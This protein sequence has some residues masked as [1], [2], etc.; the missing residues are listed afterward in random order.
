MS[1]PYS[2]STNCK[3]NDLIN[4]E[5]DHDNKSDDKYSIMCRVILKRNSSN[6]LYFLTVNVL[7]ENLVNSS[8]QIV[9]MKQLLENE[10]DLEV[11]KKITLGDVIG[12]EGNLGKTKVGEISIFA[13]NI[14]LL[15]PCL[16]DLPKEQYTVTDIDVKYRQRYL[17]MIMNAKTREN[18]LKRSKIIKSIR[19]YLDSKDYIEVETPILNTNYG[20]ANAKPFI[21]HHNDYKIDMF[22]RIAPELYLKQL[23]IGGFN[24]I[25]EI[26]KQF[27]NESVD[28]T[29]NPEFTSIE[30][31]TSPSD[32][33]NMFDLCEDIIR[34]LVFNVYG[35]YK[36]I[37][38][39]IE[40]DF[41]PKFKR[42]DFLEELRTKTDYHFN[43][44]ESE[45]TF[46]EIKNL[47]VE[48]KIKC[49]PPITM[50][51]MLDKLAGELIEVQCIQPTFIY[52]HPKIMS[53]LAKP[54]R[55]NNEITERFELFILEKE[56]ANAYT[57]LNDPEIQKNAFLKQALD[58]TN[59]D[60][61][62]QPTDMD[63]IKALE[64]GLPPTG[65]LG[66]GIDRLVMLL[67][68]EESIREIL[69]FPTMK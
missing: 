1:Y 51:R 18:L 55:S 22:M 41:E 27:R 12:I 35:K 44:L 46:N 64:Y 56:Y 65:G 36:I 7:G 11:V 16:H 5:Y 6:K 4:T 3:Y 8:I 28:S 24:K 37:F 67:T 21:T 50:P 49:P 31:Y 38:K 26:G 45:T 58:K 43:N 63:F 14:I 9:I 33:N 52:H 54:H 10:N 23:V 60:G 61:E 20:G 57:E 48:L 69:C 17:D 25:Y 34:N 19:N 47:L 68:G 29:H 59:G 39:G 42:I 66:I 13:T 40:L 62:A 15:A 53:P 32:Y 2:F 30:I